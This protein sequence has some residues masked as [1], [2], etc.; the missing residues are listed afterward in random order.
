MRKKN[1]EIFEHAVKLAGSGKYENWKDIQ[2]ELVRKGYGKAPDLLG[3]DK[4]R[5][6]L[7]FQC[8]HARDKSA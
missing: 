1:L 5:N 3:G 2:K 8:A 6:V 4:I 7:D